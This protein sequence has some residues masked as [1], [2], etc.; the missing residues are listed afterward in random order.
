MRYIWRQFALTMLFTLG[1]YAVL[2][3]LSFIVVPPTARRGWI[4]VWDMDSSLFTTAPKYAY[5]A[6]DELDTREAKILLIGASNTGAG[7][8]QGDVQA[9]VGCA[10]VSNLALGGANISEM[11][12]LVGLIDAVQGEEARRSETVILGVW[13]GMF[14]DTG[15]NWPALNGDTDLDVER[16]RYGFER[17]TDAGPVA[18]LPPSWLP[19]GVVLIR[20]YLVHEKVARTLFS[21][22]RNG[23]FD[24]PHAVADTDKEKEGLDA[25]GRA[26]AMVW[27]RRIMGPHD[28]ISSVQV[29]VLRGLVEGLLASGRAVVLVDMPIPHWHR[30]ASPWYPSYVAALHDVTASFAGRPNFVVVPT[31]DLDADVN[32]TDEVHPKPH[33][34]R[35]LAAR[36]AAVLNPLLCPGPKDA[37]A[38]SSSASP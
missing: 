35:A 30:E 15:Q 36:V 14:V 37:L 9:L 10:K 4:D 3:G 26:D 5:L 27:W 18:V 6:R 25:Q 38:T 13:Y 31:D 20:P 1:L 11:H 32:F 21:P 2:L 19:A 24:K 17:R 7:L 12:D 34:A 29:K 33:L 16:Y 8:R 22:L 23:L 28:A